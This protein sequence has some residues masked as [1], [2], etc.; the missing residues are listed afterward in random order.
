MRGPLRPERR[1]DACWYGARLW[2][3]RAGSLRIHDALIDDCAHGGRGGQ[4][5]RRAGL[6]GSGDWEREPAG[7]R[8]LRRDRAYDRADGVHAAWLFDV[9]VDGDA[10]RIIDHLFAAG[11]A[12]SLHAWC[13]TVRWNRKLDDDVGYLFADDSRLLPDL[14]VVGVIAAGDCSVYYAGATLYSALRYWR[15]RGGE[16]KGPNF[17]DGEG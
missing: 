15:G 17:V 11:G 13:R 10:G 1:E 14:V 9:T 12:C 16:W 8:K 7:L 4:T 2:S 6:S 5:K 3:G